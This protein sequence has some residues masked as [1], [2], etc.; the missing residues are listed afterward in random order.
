MIFVSRIIGRITKSFLILFFLSCFMLLTSCH[1]FSKRISDRLQVI[2]K[3]PGVTAKDNSIASM[4][5]KIKLSDY[6]IF[7]L[8]DKNKDSVAIAVAI[9]GGGYRASTFALGVMSGLENIKLKKYNKNFLQA[10]N[11]YSTVSGGGF[12][13]AF[14]L[15]QYSKYMLEN[16]EKDKTFNLQRAINKD[17]AGPNLLNM[18]LQSKVGDFGALQKS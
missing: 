8:E 9:S 2:N 15:S 18:N 17:I 10:V 7:H 11:Y 16:L 5:P 14:Y 6:K 13:A 12:A 1:F 4:P 3:Y